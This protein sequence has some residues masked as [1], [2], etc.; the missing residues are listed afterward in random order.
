[1]L[2][3]NWGFPVLGS[4]KVTRVAL[5]AEDESAKGTIRNCRRNIIK[6]YCTYLESFLENILLFNL[7]DGL[8][9]KR[10]VIFNWLKLV[11]CRKK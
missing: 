6:M 10:K 7:R 5:K 11:K 1:M 3:D 8:T 4:S 9:K 2:K